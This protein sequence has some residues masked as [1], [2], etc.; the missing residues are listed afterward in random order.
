MRTRGL[1]ILTV[2]VI[3]LGLW[4]L[5]VERSAPTTDERR[6]QADQVLPGLDQDLVTAVELTNA[7][8]TFR[9]ERDGSDDGSQRA[10]RLTEPINAT[11]DRSAVTSALS[12]LEGLEAERRLEPGEVELAA[13][14]LQAPAITVALTTATGASYRLSVGD[15]TPLGDRRAVTTDGNS[16]LL[17]PG[18]FAARLES[19]L[20][21]WRSRDLVQVRTSDVV[22]LTIDRRGE[23]VE[24]VRENERWR[25]RAPIS[26]LAERDRVEGL[27]SDINALQVEEFLDDEAAAVDLS[28][29]EPPRI[30]LTIVARA[31]ETTVLEFGPI[32]PSDGTTEQDEN[33]MLCRLNGG[34]VVRVG[35]GA[36]ARLASAV[37]SWRSSAVAP[38]NAWSVQRLQIDTG[39]DSDRGEVVTI[40]HLDGQWSSTEGPLDSTAV[41]D[42][43]SDL[44]SL[45]ILELDVQAPSTQ[46][47]ATIQVGLE[48]HQDLTVR[49]FRQETG[50]DT[51]LVQTSIRPGTFAV[52][53]SAVGTVLDTERLFVE[54]PEEDQPAATS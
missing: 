52:A 31:G 5:L 49:F 44:S 17:C 39:A 30:R 15:S 23:Q 40:E 45:E 37:R 53:G 36:E 9:L 20:D 22:S 28:A 13:Y 8:G 25:L 18:W 34:R 16:V 46:P 4:I 11:A 1:V 10:W 47:M 41:Y 12:A 14:G 42:L 19:D 21:G 7:H 27:I 26:D 54:A 51:V 24:L 38:F 43:L 48:Q 33:V 35:D 32:E 50:R 3:A 6:Q 2:V 29:L